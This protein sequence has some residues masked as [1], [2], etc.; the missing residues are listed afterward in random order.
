MSKLN[1]TMII[2]CTNIASLYTVRSSRNP[3]TYPQGVDC[4]CL[5]RII[6]K[7]VYFI[8]IH[9][10]V[11]AGFESS[12][13]FIKSYSTDNVIPIRIRDPT[14]LCSV[15]SNDVRK[16]MSL[17]YKMSGSDYILSSFCCASVYHEC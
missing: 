5:P 13:I 10:T 2:A 12:I 6:Y 8:N 16:K 9:F 11:F 14:G 1:L 7:S 4:V 3:Y 15:D 17:L